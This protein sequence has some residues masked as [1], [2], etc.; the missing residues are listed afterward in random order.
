MPKPQSAHPP[1]GQRF[2]YWLAHA[3]TQARERVDVRAET[4]ASMLDMSV[5][6]VRRFETAKHFPNDPDRMIAAYAAVAGL[7]DPRE[8]YQQALNLWYAHGSMPLLGAKND[9]ALTAGQKFEREIASRR[10]Q[11]RAPAA[12]E[13]S[14][15]AARKRRASQ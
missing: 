13:E 2:L 7:D 12:P 1:A 9:G 14:S 6:S 3:A 5:E 11:P 10:A 8:I 4:I 15:T